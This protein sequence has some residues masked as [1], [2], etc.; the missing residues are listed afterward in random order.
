MI[1]PA[2]RLRS[3]VLNQGRARRFRPGQS[4]ARW[5]P[6]QSAAVSA[7]AE[8][9]GAFQRSSH[10]GVGGPRKSA[11]GFQRGSHVGFLRLARVSRGG[12]TSATSSTPVSTHPHPLYTPPWL[13]RSQQHPPPTPFRHVL[14][15]PRFHKGYPPQFDLLNSSFL[16][17]VCYTLSADLAGWLARTRRVCVV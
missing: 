17:A 12:L 13:A 7:K 3:G 14:P 9:A 15:P 4:A 8:H 10:V 5:K 11:G 6:G 2:L 1:D 16:C